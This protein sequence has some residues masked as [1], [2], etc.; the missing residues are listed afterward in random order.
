MTENKVYLK[1]VHLETGSNNCFTLI[2]LFIYFA[3]AEAE[4]GGRDRG[5]GARAKEQTAGGSRPKAE[6]GEHDGAA[7]AGPRSQWSEFLEEPGA[8]TPAPL[9]LC[10]T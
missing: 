8:A 3:R 1:I 6:D 2:Y 5:R 7:R 10:V 9:Q 4:V